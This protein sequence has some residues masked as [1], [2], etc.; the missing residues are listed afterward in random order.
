[1]GESK[2]QTLA[3]LI[4]CR[5]HILKLLFGGKSVP[6]LVSLPVTPSIIYLAEGVQEHVQYANTHKNAVT[7][8]I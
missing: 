8:T 6:E 3:T 2:I 7:T 4:C 5:F 1:M